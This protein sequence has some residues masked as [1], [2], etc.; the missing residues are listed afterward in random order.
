MRELLR[1]LP[2]RNLRRQPLR[3][4][5]TVI[6]AACG[7]AL[8]VSIEIINASTLRYF[9]DGVRA[10]AGGAALTVS[11]SETGF[12][13][14]ERERLLSLPGVRTAV[15]SIEALAYVLRPG[16]TEPETLGVLGVD[17]R[18]ELLVRM[19]R[20]K[21]APSGSA[22][23]QSLG[24]LNAILLPADFATNRTAAARGSIDILT[25]SG[26]ARLD[27]AGTLASA[28]GESG[29]ALVDL[30][31]AQRLFGFE[32]RIT[33]LDILVDDGHDID[34]LAVAM[35]TLLGP[36]FTV[37]T[38]RARATDMQRMVR[39]YQ[40]LLRFVSLITL[41]AGA[42]VLGATMS[43]SVREQRQSIGM[44]RA[45]GAPRVKI[46]LLVLTEAATLAGVAVA[47]GVFG[48]RLAAELLVGAVSRT[49]SHTYMIPIQPTALQYPLD[50]GL[51]HAFFAWLVGIVAAMTA[52]ARAARM[53]PVQAIRPAEIQTDLRFPRW[54]AWLGVTG[55]ALAGYLGIVLA[56]RLDRDAQV[57]QTANAVV[58]L[59]AALVLA[60]TAVIAGLRLL[61]GTRIGR[62]LIDRR[63]VLRLGVGNVLRAPG[64][65]AWS[66]LLLSIGLLMFVT[67]DTLRHSLLTSVEGWIDRTVYSDLLVAS[68]GSLFMME[69]QP[70]N[71]A[72]ARDLDAIAGVRVDEGRGAMGI[73]YVTIRYAGRDVTL[74][75]FDRPHA[76]LPRLPFDMRSDYPLNRGGDIF[77][78]PR[79]AA[80][81]SENF[82]KHFGKRPGD[83]LTLDS[84]AGPLKVE[85]IGVVTD[86]A[87]PDG[88]IYLSRDLYRAYWHDPLIS[89][90]SVMVQPGVEV[91]RV[92]NAI[93]TKLGGAKGLHATNH[94]ELRQQ[95]REILNESFAYTYAIEAATLVAAIFGI[96]NSMITAVLARQRELAVLRA[97]GMSR[98]ALLR[99]IVCEGLCLSIPAAF[100]AM[101]LGSLLGYLC[102]AGVLSALM[103]WTIEFQASPWM[104]GATLA[105][106]VLSGSAASAIAAWK[107]A[108]VKL[109]EALITY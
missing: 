29:F 85:I 1:L 50:L 108:N 64:R 97:L 71:E 6:G 79:P 104:L 103:G 14:V 11:A 76:S 54:L 95:T 28:S 7:V 52:A 92:A 25:Q 109:S 39:G 35:R 78:S 38:S 73:R 4:V 98:L 46:L 72:L 33:R 82:V 22:T 81:V 17:P 84:P 3:S 101:V 69:V 80:L 90:F 36:A 16:H 66:V 68:P 60:P 37:D 91:T 12:P 75:A 96:M 83:G 43:V 105:M 61:Q 63:V 62:G 107:S 8:F 59:V 100:A 20:L 56:T 10:M 88:V 48:G 102:L 93:E 9:A 34:A 19:H 70:L 15:P 45:L 2:V 40:A 87:S 67:A 23:L 53:E 26:A 89:V 58:G 42:M 27:V 106:G 55:G 99:M 32:G 21:D 47:L 44:L 74:K 13:E 31:T 65:S 49:M 94:H 41:L 57:W 5:L 30:A 86:Y 77:G 18:L 24:S 51:L